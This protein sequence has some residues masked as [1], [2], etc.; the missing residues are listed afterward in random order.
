MRSASKRWLVTLSVT[1]SLSAVL[2]A[3]G[4]A[5][6]AD[7]T[8]KTLMKKMGATAAS[9]DAK[10]LAP[11]LAQTKSMKPADPAFNGWDAIADAAKAAAEKGDLAAAK[12]T[13]KEC[14][15]KFRDS[16]KTKYGSKA[17]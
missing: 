10:G 9:E 1:L 6:A 4:S 7:T 8:M 14:H 12:A 3:A 11:L 15:N 17:P 16:Y 13:C 5:D 2:A